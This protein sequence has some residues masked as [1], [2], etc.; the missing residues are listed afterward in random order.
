MRE[1]LARVD[2]GEDVSLA[3]VELE[4][5]CALEGPLRPFPRHHRSN[6]P[7]QEASFSLER[8]LEKFWPKI[9]IETCPHGTNG[10]DDVRKDATLRRNVM[11]EKFHGVDLEI[12]VN[13]L[14]N[15][16]VL[17]ASCGYKVLL[18]V[19]AKR[20]TPVPYQVVLDLVEERP[21]R[22]GVVGQCH[23]IVNERAQGASDAIVSGCMGIP[24]VAKR[25]RYI[26][27]REPP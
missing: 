21:A 25:L 2:D 8:R 3:L 20:K 19:C 10:V 22:Q 26:N 6:H 7:V 1:V 9:R 13:A 11:P 15:V 23:Q 27:E 12:A 4:R 17:L 24:T 5:R 18:A 14:T 16:D